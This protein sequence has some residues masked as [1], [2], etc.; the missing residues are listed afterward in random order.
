MQVP[1][2]QVKSGLRTVAEALFRG[3]HDLWFHIPRDAL[4][5]TAVG[6]ER[7]ARDVEPSQ[8][9][10]ETG[11]RRAA[12]RA[13]R[14]A[15]VGGRDLHQFVRRQGRG[16]VQPASSARSPRASPSTRLDACGV[17]RRRSALFALGGSQRGRASASLAALRRAFST[18]PHPGSQPALRRSRVRDPSERRGGGP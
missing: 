13:D 17:A 16:S 2:C 3:R 14:S 15:R 6:E 1:K 12:V 4:C 10:A 5:Y 9:D 11:T 8:R 7:R 18:R